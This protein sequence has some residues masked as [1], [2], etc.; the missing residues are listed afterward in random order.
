MLAEADVE[1]AC[2][3]AA[4]AVAPE[5]KRRRR[6]R[7]TPVD[8]EGG[9]SV[10]GPCVPTFWPRFLDIWLVAAR[11]RCAVLLDSR[12]APRGSP[13]LASVLFELQ[14]QQ[15]Q[16]Q[17]RRQHCN[18]CPRCSSGCDVACLG[19]LFLEESCFLV[20]R[21]ML[22]QR[23]G[24]FHSV[25]STIAAGKVENVGR[26]QD[27]TNTECSCS[28]RCGVPR[29]PSEGQ[30]VEVTAVGPS[31][32][33]EGYP[34]PPAGKS[35]AA[36]QQ[37][38]Q[39]QGPRRDFALVDVRKSLASPCNHSD[40]LVPKLHAALRSAFGDVA[41]A[42][43]AAAAAADS[44]GRGDLT[45]SF[46]AD[47]SLP[48]PPG[49]RSSSHRVPPRATEATAKNNAE[50]MSSGDGGR[51]F[52][53]APARERQGAR[54]LRDWG[55]MEMSLDCESL[56]K[57]LGDVG[58]PGLAGWLLEYPV[59]YCCPSLVETTKDYGDRG[60]DGALRGAATG[61]ETEHEV[62]NCL[63]VVPLTVF[64]LIFD[65]D[66]DATGCC[67]PPPAPIAFTSSHSTGA[68]ASH[69]F[70]FSVPETMCGTTEVEK[71]EQG[72]LEET[73]LQSLVDIFLGRLE[74]R[75]ARHRRRHG[76]GDCC[77]CGLHQQ[78]VYG[79]TVTKRTETLDRVAL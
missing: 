9:W 25:E 6:P 10:A 48:P 35:S 67:S 63:P 43:A 50:E 57:I 79:L 15:Q 11:V 33:L 13:P 65:T 27:F 30:P 54:W 73:N 46:I 31:S 20:N 28:G 8:D 18:G 39:R 68:T 2:R 17:Q 70:S 1:R 75:I 12:R 56:G 52:C 51:E 61:T 42:A 24:D 32:K 7:A 40:F 3:A 77:C 21:V 45:S 72:G 36:A 49:T 66:K 16:Q 78:S 19:L 37:Q 59:I 60:E 26:A 5:P 53:R 38:R 14:H 55:M 64:S 41:V 74:S 23:L 4:R 69:A 29:D 47:S 22:L 34:A 71:G 62:G 76:S 58:L 44:C